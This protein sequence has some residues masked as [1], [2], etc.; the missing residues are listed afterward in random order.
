MHRIRA[1]WACCLL[2]TRSVKDRVRH[3]TSLKSSIERIIE[4]IT[5]TG[6]VVVLVV[7]PLLGV[8]VPEPFAMRGLVET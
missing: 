4:S 1:A 8:W 6:V 2:G 3:R 5:F 7:G